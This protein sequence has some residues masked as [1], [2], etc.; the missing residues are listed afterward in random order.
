MRIT[1]PDQTSVVVGFTSMGAAKSQVAIQHGK[2]TDKAAVSAREGVLGRAA[3][4][5]EGG[6]EL[7]LN[8]VPGAA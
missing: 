5:A 2:L 6:A 3:G 8:C 1:W 4:R 7:K